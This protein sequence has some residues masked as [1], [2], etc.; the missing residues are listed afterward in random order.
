MRLALETLILRDTATMARTLGTQSPTDSLSK[1]TVAREGAT[2][3]VLYAGSQY[4]CGDIGQEYNLLPDLWLEVTMGCNTAETLR[5][6]GKQPAKRRQENWGIS[7]ARGPD[8]GTHC[9]ASSHA[10]EDDHTLYN[11]ESI[12]AG[13]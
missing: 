7:R 2:A 10:E 9:K 6:R 13:Q 4:R 8:L 1:P 11:V 5:L 12:Q 3:E